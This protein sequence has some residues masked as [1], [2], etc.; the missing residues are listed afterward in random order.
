MRMLLC[1]CAAVGAGGWAMIGA[2]PDF[3]RTINRPPS[4]VYA[5]FS[6][7]APEETHSVART[8]DTPELL[9]RVEKEENREIQFEVLADGNQVVSVTLN[10]AP[11]QGGAA[12]R[13]TAELDID[14][15]KL[16]SLEAFGSAKEAILPADVPEPLIDMAFNRVMQDMVDDVEAGRPLELGASSADAWESTGGTS[17]SES[18]SRAAEAQRA[19]SR[20][21]TRPAPMV[22]PNQAAR[23]YMD[24]GNDRSP[25]ESGGWAR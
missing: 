22:D 17:R 18:R 14:Q 3:D 19:A 21:M 20:P 10:F 23:D 8:S 4:A 16:R 12:T 2:G 7:I 6:A 11:A 5:A 13:V 1:S 15:S 24:G 25:L 9:A